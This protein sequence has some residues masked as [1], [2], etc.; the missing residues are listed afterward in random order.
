M[1]IKHGDIMDDR[2]TRKCDVH[3]THGLLYVCPEYDLEKQKE[4]ELLGDKFKQDCKNGK[5]NIVNTYGMR[6]NNI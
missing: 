2:S 4:V 1:S 5:V 3:G 6:R